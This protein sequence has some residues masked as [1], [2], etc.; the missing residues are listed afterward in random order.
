MNQ[1]TLLP[2]RA[3]LVPFSVTGHIEILVE[4]EQP[5]SVYV[6]DQSGRER[7]QSGD[8]GGALLGSYNLTKHA[9]RSFIG[10]SQWFLVI[11]NVGPMPT[12]GWYSVAT[13]PSGPVPSG[14]FPVARSTTTY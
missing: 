2:E 12:T 11:E 13:V 5:V 1:F 9:L 4:T 7:L 10:L 3:L 14:M 6:M 8:R